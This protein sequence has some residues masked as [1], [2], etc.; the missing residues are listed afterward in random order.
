[1]YGVS[2]YDIVRRLYPEI[3]KVMC[4]E[5]AAG[6]IGLSKDWGVPVSVFY[7]T[8]YIINSEY[9]IGIKVPRL[10]ELQ[11]ITH[12]GFEC[13]SREQTICDLFRFPSSVQD[14]SEGLLFYYYVNNGIDGVLELAEK[15]EL[16][17]RIREELGFL[18]EYYE[19]PEDE[20]DEPF[21]VFVWDGVIK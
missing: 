4:L 21:S 9:F 18:L 17:G 20:S 19:E 2:P 1:M 6:R 5:T 3:R 16:V 7:D 12:C 13:T 11:V 14:R 15:Y 10:D 8:G